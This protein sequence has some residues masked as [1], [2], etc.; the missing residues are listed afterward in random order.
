MSKIRVIYD[1][2]ADRGALVTSTS[3]GNMTADKLLTD[4]KSVVWRSTSKAGQMITITFPS[5]EIVSTV[6]LMFTNL[7]ATATIKVE[8]YTLSGDAIAA[9]DTGVQNAGAYPILGK[10]ANA[11]GLSSFR[12]GGATHGRSYFSAASVEK[13]VI[14]IDDP[15]NVANYVEVGRLVI[16]DY[17]TPINNIERGMAMIAKDTSSHNRSGAGDLI[18]IPGS[19]NREITMNMAMMELQDRATM[20]SIMLANGKTRPVF[21]SIFPADPDPQLEHDHMIYGKL[22]DTSSFVANTY[23][24]YTAP[25]GIS[26]I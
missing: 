9:F 21:I 23:S 13:L 1:N 15:D 5:P 17:W 20:W 10:A 25:M 2:I 26:E 11:K 7:T 14:T 24:A 3:A 12:T 8:G 6:A 16:G 22:T 19:K 18:T 4:V